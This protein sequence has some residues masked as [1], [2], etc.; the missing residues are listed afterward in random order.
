MTNR[1]IKLASLAAGLL[2]LSSP[3]VW[4]QTSPSTPPAEPTAA[5]PP[6]PAPITTVEGERHNMLAP[7]PAAPPAPTA[8]T[9]PAM[10]F[11]LSANSTPTKF[12]VG[13]LGTWYV[14][15][16]VSGLA[17]T[18]DHS[19]AGDAK[20]RTDLSNGQVFIQK[21]DGP[22]QFF[23]QAGVYSLPDLGL[24]Y[25]RAGDSLNAFYGPLPVAFVKFVPNDKISILAGKLPTLIGAETT[26]DFEDTNIERGLLWNQENAVTRG[27]QLNYTSGPIA[28][29]LTW[30]DGF[31][32]NRYNWLT[33]MV[34]YTIDSSNTLCLIGGKSTKRTTINTTATPILLNNEQIYNLIY[35]HI[36]GPWT[37]QPYL[38]Y[39]RVPASAIIGNLKEAS[40]TGAAVFINYTFDAKSELAGFSLPVR[41]ER[42]ISTGSVADGSPNLLYGPG[43]KAWSITV[44]PTYQY[45]I[46]FV[47]GELSYVKA[48]GV[49]SGSGF[50][51]FGR[52]TN[53]TRALIETGMLF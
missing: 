38:Q 52:N 53:Q 36:A 39:S 49:T 3:H 11:P 41:L 35:T 27:V 19:F 43:S 48:S 8:M 42:I 22:V 18:Q 5:T 12:D 23:V 13:S 1:S 45:K 34:T 7:P 4:A 46:F 14:T 33:G 44:T 29:S 15:G 10:S 37:F 40:T 24:P 51:P 32:S 20:N 21:V 50:G 25:I 6:A 9:T 30:T 31:Y 47:R 17:F 28:A 16:A 2:A 26:F